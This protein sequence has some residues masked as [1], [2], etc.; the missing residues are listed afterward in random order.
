MDAVKVGDLVTTKLGSRVGCIIEIKKQRW[1]GIC[2]K[3]LF[4]DIGT[5]KWMKIENIKL[6]DKTDRGVYN[7]YRVQT[8]DD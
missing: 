5:T 6:L 2:A 8:K 1:A 4:F 7:G 3:V